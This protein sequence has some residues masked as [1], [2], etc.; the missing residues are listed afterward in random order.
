MHGQ[1]LT[2]NKIVWI[3]VVILLPLLGAILY[4]S[5]IR[6][7]LSRVARS[8]NPWT[9][10]RPA[11]VPGHLLTPNLDPERGRPVNQV[12]PFRTAFSDVNGFVRHCV[13]ERFLVLIDGLDEI[14]FS[15]RRKATM[16]IQQ[17]SRSISE[18]SKIVISCRSA[19]YQ[20]VLEG[21]F[22][23][24]LMPLSEDQQELMLRELIGEAKSQEF[25]EV[26]T[27]EHPAKDL[28]NRPLFLTQMAA[29]FIRTGA[30]PERPVDLYGAM[31]RLVIQD[32]DADRGVK[33]TSRYAGF[34]EDEKRRFLSSIALE[35]LEANKIRFS[36]SELEDA[37]RAVHV[38]FGL[39]RGEAA[40][41]AREVESHTGLVVRSGFDM[42]E[43]SHLSL[44]EYLAGDALSRSTT[45]ARS[46]WSGSTAVAAVAVALSADASAA[47]QE[48]SSIVYG[49]QMSSFLGRLAHEKPRFLPDVRL[50][51]LMLKALH[52]RA[53]SL[54]VLD[55]ERLGE[56]AGLRA[57]VTDSLKVQSS[58]M[59]FDVPGQP[60]MVGIIHL[61]TDLIIDRLVLEALVGEAT[62]ENIGKTLATRLAIGKRLRTQDAFRD[63][64]S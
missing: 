14:P 27:E 50:G 24:E 55:A 29:I 4:L 44:Q 25:S 8:E 26:V 40:E 19:D 48:F 54:G 57:S 36:G 20:P 31:V 63:R 34:D 61:G 10:G 37:Y 60:G 15:A 58:Y 49:T 12:G 21:F 23:A 33:R 35:L 6:G 17:L 41:V 32:W 2:K 47:L 18:S 3:L 42:Y 56:V 64:H 1:R 53:S 43:F 22:A 16:E 39:P 28:T 46:E 13:S 59:D 52:L 62:L 51:M 45:E 5:M 30:V 7:K 11:T 9:G 38:G